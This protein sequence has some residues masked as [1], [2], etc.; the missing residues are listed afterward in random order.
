MRMPAGIDVRDGA[1]HVLAFP[2]RA[3]ARLLATGLR[4]LGGRMRPG[5]DLTHIVTRGPV[6]IESAGGEGCLATTVDRLY[7]MR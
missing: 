7:L 3:K 1:L 5:R 6:R 2:Q 4:A